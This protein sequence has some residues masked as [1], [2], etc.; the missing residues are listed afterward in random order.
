M[1][2]QGR[3]ARILRLA[4]GVA[5]SA[6]L[7]SIPITVNA[8]GGGGGGGDDGNKDG[9]SSAKPQDP[10]YTAAV[11]A[12]K[13]GEFASAVPLLEGVVTREGTNADAHNWLAYAVR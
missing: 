12:I 2:T 11:K 7:A 6:L 13:A 4:V 1:G 8:D 10:D 3:Y 9:G 5:L